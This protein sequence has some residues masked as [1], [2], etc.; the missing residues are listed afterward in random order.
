M[1][2][3]LFPPKIQDEQSFGMQGRS[4]GPKDHLAAVGEK[5]VKMN[6]RARF[7]VVAVMSVLGG[8]GA[9]PLWAAPAYEVIDIGQA[10]AFYTM[11]NRWEAVGQAYVAGRA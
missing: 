8:M 2:T 5:A 10:G 4:V 3:F 11:N 6:R 7:A 1:I 9:G